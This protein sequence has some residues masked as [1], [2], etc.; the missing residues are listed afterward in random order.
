LPSTFSVFPNRQDGSTD[1][2]QTS[3][4]LFIFK[5]SQE[6]KNLISALLFLMPPAINWEMKT[7]ELCAA[8]AAHAQSRQAL[9]STSTPL[10]RSN[11]LKASTVR[12][13]DV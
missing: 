10:G 5:L 9:I 6:R 7:K 2:K 12:E 11:L 13:D 3:K 8:S 4:G 1:S